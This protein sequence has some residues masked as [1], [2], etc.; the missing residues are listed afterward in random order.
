[1]RI[2]SAQDEIH[3]L[4]KLSRLMIERVAIDS[5][6]YRTIITMQKGVDGMLLDISRNIVFSGV[7]QFEYSIR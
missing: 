3:V 5:S 1:M 2:W 6:K 7:A 4:C